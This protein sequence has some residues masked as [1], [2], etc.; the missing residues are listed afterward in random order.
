MKNNNLYFIK[1]LS[2][3]DNKVVLDSFEKDRSIISLKGDYRSVLEDIIALNIL[4]NK[5]IVIVTN[6]D[7]SLDLSNINLNSIKLDINDIDKVNF[8][9][10]TK[11]RIKKVLNSNESLIISKINLLSREIDKKIDL[12]KDIN[13]FFTN[14]DNSKL[15]ILD[16]YNLS[17]RKIGKCDNRYEYYKTFIEKK[18]FMNYSY[19]EVKDT[20]DNLLEKDASTNYN[21]YKRFHD[22]KSFDKID[23]D[24]KVKDI[25]SYKS[26]IQ[27]ILN[28]K[29]NLEIK[30]NKT[31]YTSDF[32]DAYILNKEM[33]GNDFN[34][35]AENINKKYNSDLINKTFK[36]KMTNPLYWVRK[37]S[38]LKTVEENRLKYQ[39]EQNNIYENI[40]S[41]YN[42]V[43]TYIKKFS[44]LQK[45]LTASEFDKFILK[46]LNEESL[47]E[48]LID[49]K[50]TLD[51]Y[52]TFSLIKTSLTSLNS[53]EEEILDYCYNNIGIKNQTNQL[54]KFI[55]ELYVYSK[56]E[57]TEN[58]EEE[59]LHY[60][61]DYEIILNDIYVNLFK[62][63]ELLASA[64]EC[65]YYKNTNEFMK[66]KDIDD[67]N[68]D[69][70]I[71][72]SLKDIKFDSSILLTDN[73]ITN[74][75]PLVIASK[76]EARTLINCTKSPYNSFVLINTNVEYLNENDFD[77]INVVD[78]E[79]SKF[80]LFKQKKEKNCFKNEMQNDISSHLIKNG[81]SVE[82][83]VNIHGYLIDVLVYDKKSNE[84]ILCIE[85]D[86]SVYNE[87]FIVEK[88][89]VFKKIVFEEIGISYI[90]LWSRD[91]WNDRRYELN[92]I[93]SI[94]EKDN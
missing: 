53:L 67:I 14:K 11:D 4:N 76:E 90:R 34:I 5:K 70:F 31:E 50:R 47:D 1:G 94:I 66:E 57:D 48:S 89:D 77:I 35:L 59:T 87:N 74:I 6:E 75:Y 21:K 27:D 23:K 93:I 44:F 78:E 82:R 19:K 80:N 26:K 64:A 42:L 37:K 69:D 7:S 92:K 25:I 54:L 61:N 3:N 28:D 24:L 81:Y 38:Y 85:C 33:S 72:N 84:V 32:I 2:Y 39:E 46:I 8:N 86:R 65:Q 83:D 18:P 45:V 40:L 56:I 29:N 15:T 62:K 91:W 9:N 49:I 30:L 13:I 51:N 60:Y 73:L 22:N 17:S 10:E 63:K 20:I 43:K 58:T 71:E 41:N 36:Y 79:N 88:D 55:P 16:A 52:E 68:K 12:L